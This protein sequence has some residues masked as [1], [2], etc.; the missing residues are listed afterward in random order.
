[1]E[2]PQNKPL[3]NLGIYKLADKTMILWKRS[4]E[5]SFLFSEHNWHFHGAVNYRVSHGAIYLRGHR[6]PWIDEDLEDTGL[7][8]TLPGWLF[9]Y[10][11]EE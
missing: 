11:I 5:L 3:R 8:A 6:T 1:M 2:F 7:T 10:E 4:E 9:P